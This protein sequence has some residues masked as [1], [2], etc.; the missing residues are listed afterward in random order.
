[1]NPAAR[2]SSA[3]PLGAH[4]PPGPVPPNNKPGQRDGTSENTP[5]AAAPGRTPPGTV[6]GYFTRREKIGRL[7]WTLVQATLFRF[8]PRRADAWRAWLLRRFG[9]RVGRVRL[10][11]NTVRVEVPWNVELGDG[12]Q[13]GDRVYL[14]SLGKISIGEHSIVSQF[15]H[16]CAGTHDFERTDFP[17]LRVPIKVGARCWLAAETFVG[18]GVT[19]ADG[20][21]VGARGGVVKDLPAWTVCVGSPARPVG[22]R[23]LLDNKTGRRLDLSSGD[24]R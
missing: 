16:L 6:H 14:Y 9:A 17:L 5:G 13:I 8:S 20:V 23:R 18:P 4:T 12:V 24:D 2:P 1:M 15:S 21:V 7:L 22:P 19:I 10:L 3:T 11:R